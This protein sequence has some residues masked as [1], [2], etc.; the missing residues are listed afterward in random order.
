VKL[1]DS[2]HPFAICTIVFW[3]SAY[4]F[5]RLALQFFAPLSLGFLRY[6]IAS[7]LLIIFV[8][9]VKIKTPNKKDI[10][11]FILAGFF[12]FFLYMVTFN[13]GSAT[14][15]ASTSSVIIATTPAVTTLLARIF[16][17]E[18]LKIT[19][20]IAVIIEFAGVNVLTLMNGI[21]SVNIGLI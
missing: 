13:L 7:L 3:S 18:K 21:F 17:K 12:G 8:L 19:Q 9:F 10:K 20:Y 4:V 15:T 16:Y 1:K 14:V 6:F 11:W 5:T 2:F